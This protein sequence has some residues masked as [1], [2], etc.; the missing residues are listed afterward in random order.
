MRFFVQLAL[1]FGTVFFGGATAA[2]A[3]LGLPVPHEAVDSTSVHGFPFREG[4]PCTLFVG[5]I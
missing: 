4:F 1:V 3:E 5:I 2:L